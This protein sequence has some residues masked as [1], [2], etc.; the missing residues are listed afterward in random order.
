MYIVAYEINSG[1][2]VGWIDLNTA[3]DHGVIADLQ[4]EKAYQG[5]SIARKLLDYARRY[6]PEMSL[7]HGMTTE[8]GEAWRKSLPLE[9][10]GEIKALAL[11]AV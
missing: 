9:L 7:S 11:S 3:N 4:V 8:Q 1:K 6:D 5:Q 2:K 10:Q